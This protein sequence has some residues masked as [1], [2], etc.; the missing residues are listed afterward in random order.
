MRFTKAKKFL[1][2]KVRIAEDLSFFSTFL[3]LH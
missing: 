3:Q 2:K 1:N